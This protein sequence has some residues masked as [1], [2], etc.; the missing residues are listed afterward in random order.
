M[1]RSV[2]AEVH[3]YEVDEEIVLIAAGHW[4]C[5]IPYS[6]NAVCEWFTDNYHKPAICKRISAK[7]VTIEVEQ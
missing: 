6:C 3:V 2:K 5:R 7:T 4:P 1:A